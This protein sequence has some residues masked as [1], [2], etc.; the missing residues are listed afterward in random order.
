VTA[1][2]TLGVTLFA[3]VF[4]APACCIM[5]CQMRFVEIQTVLLSEHGDVIET[6][7]QGLPPQSFLANSVP[8]FMYRGP[9]LI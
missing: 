2:K 9:R 8:D 3:A 4:G 1:G 7:K 5:G 6:Q